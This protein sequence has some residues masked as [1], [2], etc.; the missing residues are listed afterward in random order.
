MSVA[1]G[2]TCFTLD[3]RTRRG[4]GKII[5]NFVTSRERMATLGGV[6]HGTPHAKVKVRGV[7]DNRFS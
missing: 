7:K 4:G 5:N 3:V 6:R 1:T 2:S